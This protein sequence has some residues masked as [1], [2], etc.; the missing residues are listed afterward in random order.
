ME[1]FLER[2]SILAP[3][4][5]ELCYIVLFLIVV[6]LFVLTLLW[7]YDYTL[8]EDYIFTPIMEYLAKHKIIKIQPSVRVRVHF[9]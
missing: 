5:S 6:S 2:L 7:M 4:E 8:V 1:V 9:S 3:S